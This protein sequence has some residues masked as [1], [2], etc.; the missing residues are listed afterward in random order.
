L[1]VDGG[2]RAGWE[3]V[4]AAILGADEYGFGSIAMIAEGCVMARVCHLNTCPVGV[5]TQ[6]E[7][8]R[9]KFKGTPENVVDFFFFLAQEVREVM[10]HLGYRSINELIG[11]TQ[12]LKQKDNLNIEK[13]SSVD[14]SA[15][16]KPE[17][18]YTNLDWLEQREDR[19]HYNGYVLDDDLLF[20]DEF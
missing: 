18:V 7:D 6:R 9:A 17:D 4:M 15:V 2:I 8:L 13:S 14:L 19:A 20:D 10:A 5:A 16:L 11:Q 3:V 1:R 12:L